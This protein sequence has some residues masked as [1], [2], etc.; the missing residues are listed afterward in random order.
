ML[1]ELVNGKYRIH[2]SFLFILQ[3]YC[4]TIWIYEIDESLIH[5][6]ATVKIAFRIAGWSRKL[7]FGP[8]INQVHMV[9]LIV[10][11]MIQMLCL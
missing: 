10:T 7:S 3:N 6:L 5:A 1:V 2:G 11:F 9:R 8:T 4:T